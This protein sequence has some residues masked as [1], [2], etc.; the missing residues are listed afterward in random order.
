MFAEPE[1][2]SI[3]DVKAFWP[4][5]WR[6][7]CSSKVE[8]RNRPPRMKHELTSVHDLMM[9][10]KNFRNIKTRFAMKT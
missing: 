2:D 10:L 8:H 5:L 9:E 7:C 3:T 1:N 6:V 4:K